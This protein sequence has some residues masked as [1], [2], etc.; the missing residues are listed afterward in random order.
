MPGLPIWRTASSGR[1]KLSDG[2]FWF[3]NLIEFAELCYRAWVKTG[4]QTYRDLID[5]R[6]AEIRRVMWT[7]EFPDLKGRWDLLQ[8]HFGIHRL[9][10]PGTTEALHAA[11]DNYKRGFALIAQGYVGSS[12]SA[13][14]AGEF[15]TFGELVW[16]LS[17][18]TRAEWQRELRRAWSQEESGVD[19]P[20]SPP[21]R[22]VLTDGL[23]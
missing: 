16:Q 14:V 9:W 2:W 7:Y 5:S 11:L 18:E 10:R 4:R 20:A 3:A 8:G 12:G 23:R 13:A 17:P 22:A 19:A 21:G 6:E 15:K 1:E